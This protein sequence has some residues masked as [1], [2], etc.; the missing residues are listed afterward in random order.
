MMLRVGFIYAVCIARD[1]IREFNHKLDEDDNNKWI[2][3]LKK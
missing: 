3:I 1:L 2:I